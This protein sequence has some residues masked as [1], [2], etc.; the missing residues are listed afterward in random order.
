VG[1]GAVVV[2]ERISDADPTLLQ[3][4]E[5]RGVVLDAELL[6]SEGAQFSDALH[7]S[8]AASD[9]TFSLGRSGTDALYV[10]RKQQ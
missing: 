3:F 7:I 10:S 8:V 4:F 5:E 1:A 2:V 9:V 6:I